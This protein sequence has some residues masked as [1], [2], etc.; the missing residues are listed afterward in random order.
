MPRVGIEPGTLRSKVAHST[1][2]LY[3]PACTAR[4][5]KCI[6]YRTNTLWR[7]Q[8]LR[9]TIRVQICQWLEMIYWSWYAQVVRMIDWSFLICRRSCKWLIMSWYVQVLWMINWSTDMPMSCKWFIGILIHPILA[10]DWSESWCYTQSRVPGCMTSC[11][12]SDGG[13]W[14]PVND[15]TVR[16]FT[17]KT[18][19]TLEFE[20]SVFIYKFYSQTTHFT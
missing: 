20:Y 14:L 16:P 15:T 5:Y 4:Q 9:M 13:G 2:S 18:P 3:K 6:I 7:T 19:T 17:I 12:A 8:V 1:K 11:A 10:N